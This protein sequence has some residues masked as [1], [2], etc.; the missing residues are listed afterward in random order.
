MQFEWDVVVYI[1]GLATMWGS[2][3]QQVRTLEKKV[4]KHNNLVERIY[5][6]E[7]TVQDQGRD[8]DRCFE[9]IRSIFAG[10]KE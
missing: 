4:E 1:L 10:D 8:I 2:I 6:M 5:K 7:T 3:T 9:K